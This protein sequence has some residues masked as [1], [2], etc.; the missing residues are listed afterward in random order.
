[1]HPEGAE[2]ENSS[3]LTERGNV[4]CRSYQI[5]LGDNRNVFRKTFRF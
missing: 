4:K 3:I 1:M 2:K 5:K